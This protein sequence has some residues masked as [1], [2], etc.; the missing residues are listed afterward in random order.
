M[1][2]GSAK[3]QI[4]LLT[5]KYPDELRLEIARFVTYYNHVR[6][7]E[8]IGNITPDDVYFGRRDQI[9]K[10]H[11]ELKTRTT[12]DRKRYN[13]TINRTQESKSPTVS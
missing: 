2:D 8:A 6:Y 1:R 10:W 5:Y 3:E 7:H 4:Y 13:S 12:V 9:L 11:A